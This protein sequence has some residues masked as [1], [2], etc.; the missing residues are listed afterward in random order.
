MDFLFDLISAAS[1][2]NK[3]NTPADPK[4]FFFTIKLIHLALVLGVVM[5]GGVVLILTTKQFSFTPSYTNP[6]ILIACLGCIGSLALSFTVFPICRKLKAPGSVSSALQRYQTFCLI[7]WSMIEGGALLSGVTMFVTRNVLS[8]VFFVISAAFLIYRYPSQKEFV[9]LMGDR[10]D[11][12]KT[13]G[14]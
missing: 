9:G 5:F 4:K 2:A 1:S 7:R 11:D 10:K 13:V 14:P 8:V 12:D 3:T 6:I